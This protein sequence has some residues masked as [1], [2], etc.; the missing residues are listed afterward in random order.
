VAFAATSNALVAPVGVVRAASAMRVAPVEMTSIAKKAKAAKY[1]LKSQPAIVKRFKVTST[2]KLMRHRAGKAH[3]LTKK[4]PQRKQRLKRM[5]QVAVGQLKTM[6]KMMLVVR[7]T[8]GF[9][10]PTQPGPPGQALLLPEQPARVTSPG[11][12]RKRLRPK[13]PG[14]FPISQVPKR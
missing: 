8:L 5:D 3:I 2:G 10:S 13:T 1:K 14:A 6:Q 9:A 7:L 11:I 12:L 4:R